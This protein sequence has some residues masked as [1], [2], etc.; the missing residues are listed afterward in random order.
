VA[1]SIFEDKT[2]KP[3]DKMISEAL[4]KA[5]KLWDELKSYVLEEYAPA[6]EEWKYYNS[7]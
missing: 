4:G 7:K 2:K 6:T 5:R 1:S 3:D